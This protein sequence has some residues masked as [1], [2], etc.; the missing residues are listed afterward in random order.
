MMTA[1]R[2]LLAGAFERRIQAGGVW[3]LTAI[4]APPWTLYLRGLRA[5]GAGAAAPISLA[6]GARIEIDWRA[7]AGGA[8]DLTRPEA[9]D[10]VLPLRADVAILHEPIDRLYA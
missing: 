6:P 4:V 9:V 5:R 7:D 2:R 10:A 1:K 8:A 3:R